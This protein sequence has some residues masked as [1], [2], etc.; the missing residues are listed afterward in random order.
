[1]IHILSHVIHESK[2]TPNLLRI[3]SHE[4]VNKA[5]FVPRA[6]ATHPAPNLGY[7]SPPILNKLPPQHSPAQ[8]HDDDERQ[9]SQDTTI[10]CLE[11]RD[12][13]CDARLRCAIEAAAHQGVESS[14]PGRHPRPQLSTRRVSH[15][16]RIEP[17]ARLCA[18]YRC[19]SLITII[20]SMWAKARGWLAAGA[21]PEVHQKKAH[22]QQLPLYNIYLVSSTR[23]GVKCPF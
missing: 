6:L 3:E 1:M 13:N 17:L 19:R 7:N 12:P 23:L 22:T 5:P 11:F 10:R 16:R 9:K 4:H 2:N 18:I 21:D 15:K 8:Q 20:Y 14:G